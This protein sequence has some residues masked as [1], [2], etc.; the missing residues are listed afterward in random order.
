MKEFFVLWKI[1]NYVLSSTMVPFLM[2]MASVGFA[3]LCQTFNNA[4]M[5]C[6]PGDYYTAY[7]LSKWLDVYQSNFIHDH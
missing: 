7:R 6:T 3:I 5:N 4:M 2:L 1:I